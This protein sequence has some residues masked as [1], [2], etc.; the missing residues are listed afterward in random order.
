MHY[1]CIP[2]VLW[3]RSSQPPLRQAL[4]QACISKRESL[5]LQAKQANVRRLEL[6]NRKMELELEERKLKLIEHWRQLQDN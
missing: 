4:S 2:N 5:E 3:S 1:E 6:E